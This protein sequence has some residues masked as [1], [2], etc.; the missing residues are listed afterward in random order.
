MGSLA[1]DPSTSQDLSLVRRRERGASDERTSFV[2][3]NGGGS[4]DRAGQGLCAGIGFLRLEVGDLD[5]E[6]HRTEYF[7]TPVSVIVDGVEIENELEQKETKT[8]KVFV[9]TFK[10]YVVASTRHEAW[11]KKVAFAETHRP[12]WDEGLS[13][14]DPDQ[15]IDVDEVDAL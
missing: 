5:K 8:K 13:E 14:Q 10:A 7:G 3:R 4:S 9:A 11:M 1:G 12:L 6:K 2:R 15:I